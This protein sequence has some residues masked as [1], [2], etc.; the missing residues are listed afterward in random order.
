VIFREALVA[1]KRTV[2]C[3]FAGPRATVYEAFQELLL[4]EL[5][6]EHPPAE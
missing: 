2:A 1:G 6:S 4:D 3:L 5:A